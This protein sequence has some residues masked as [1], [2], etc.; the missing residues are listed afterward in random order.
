M[1][2]TQGYLILAAL[3]FIAAEIFAFA[4]L[5]MIFLP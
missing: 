1:T 4:A 3:Y 2:E 5:A